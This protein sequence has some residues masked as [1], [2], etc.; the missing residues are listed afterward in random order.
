MNIKILIVLALITNTKLQSQE[1]SIIG[2]WQTEPR[3]HEFVTYD[4]KDSNK[5][6]WVVRNDSLKIIQAFTA[7]YI[8][9]QG[10]EYW[11]IDMCEFVDKRLKGISFRSI[12][13]VLSDDKIKLDGLPSNAGNRPE[14]FS[15][16]AL[17]FSRVNVPPNQQLPKGVPSP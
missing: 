14:K 12:M 13:E 4:F 2:K 5:V 8:I 3:P 6:V 9:R 1:F 17:I 11:E 15:D 10:K 7:K 16:Q